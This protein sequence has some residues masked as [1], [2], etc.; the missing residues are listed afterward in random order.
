MNRGPAPRVVRAAKQW[1][2][3]LAAVALLLLSASSVT[4]QYPGPWHYPYRGLGLP[5]SGFGFG[6]GAVPPVLW[7][8][9]PYGAGRLGIGIG[10]EPW[11][12]GFFG[13]GVGI[14]IGGG[15]PFGLSRFDVGGYPHSGWHFDHPFYGPGPLYGAYRGSQRSLYVNPVESLY[16]DRP[17]DY[18]TGYRGLPPAAERTAPLNIPGVPR[19]TPGDLRPGMVLPDGARVI[20]VDPPQSVGAGLN[21]QPVEQPEIFSPDEADEAEEDRDNELLPPPAALPANEEASE[22]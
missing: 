4:A 17:A 10:Y 14:S 19:N 16:L 22:A 1:W 15:F 18:R 12:Y 13:R 6:Y 9:Y 11:G 5:G 21:E 2:G 7:R 20:S 8:G 3:G